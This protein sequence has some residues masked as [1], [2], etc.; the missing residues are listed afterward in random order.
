MRVLH[1]GIRLTILDIEDLYPHSLMPGYF[2]RGP[3]SILPERTAIIVAATP[4]YRQTNEHDIYLLDYKSEEVSLLVEHPS[5]DYHPALSP[6]GKQ[7]AFVSDRDDALHIYLADAQG[8]NTERLTANDDP[9]RSLPL[10]T[11]DQ[12]FLVHYSIYYQEDGDFREALNLVNVDTG[13]ST[14]FFARRSISGYDFSPDRNSVVVA[15]TSF[16]RGLP[17]PYTP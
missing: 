15:R 5:N 10:W 4:A 2:V 9:F 6:D 7:I 14:R 8:Q 13:E 3:I 1:P 17:L 11:A 12:R 16:W